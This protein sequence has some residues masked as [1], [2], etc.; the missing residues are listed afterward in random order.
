MP[1]HET[2]AAT[3]QRDLSE[4]LLNEIVQAHRGP[5][6]GFLRARLTAPSDALRLTEATFER[7]A[8]RSVCDP[9]DDEIRRQLLAISTTLL[10]EHVQRE[11]GSGNAGWTK[12]CL[13]CEARNDAGADL[14]S[15]QTS[16]RMRE[17]VQAL[18][19]AEREAID[20]AYRSEFALDQIGERMRRSENAVR[21]L[22]WRARR[23]LQERLRS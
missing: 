21:Q 9:N 16:T 18:V 22:L 4:A 19:P 6:Y 8:A 14:Q 7:F 1:D 3:R 11:G 17:G 15:E 5:I 13:D 10:H 2:P 12:L 23:T 20:L